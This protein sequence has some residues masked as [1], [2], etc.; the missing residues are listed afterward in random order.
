MNS[1]S[2]TQKALYGVKIQNKFDYGIAGGG[3]VELR[4]KESR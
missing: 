2:D 4:T 1:L 3:G